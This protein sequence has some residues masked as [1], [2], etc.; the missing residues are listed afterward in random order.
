MKKNLKIKRKS[1][2][3]KIKSF[4][5][6]K[7]SIF[8]VSKSLHHKIVKSCSFYYENFKWNLSQFIVTYFINHDKINFINVN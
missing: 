8:H 1:I 2:R 6:I 7:L 3:N 5:K 4:R